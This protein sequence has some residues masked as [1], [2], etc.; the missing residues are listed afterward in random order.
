MVHK[1]NTLKLTNASE[2]D[3]TLII[4]PTQESNKYSSEISKPQ[5]KKDLKDVEDLYARKGNFSRM[6][7]SQLVTDFVSSRNSLPTKAMNR[8]LRKSYE[9]LDAEHS[10]VKSLPKLGAM[11]KRNSTLSKAKTLQKEGDHLSA[12]DLNKTMLSK[13]PGLNMSQRNSFLYQNLNRTLAQ[14]KPSQCGK[15][16]IFRTSQDFSLEESHKMS[17][18][19]LKNMKVLRHVPAKVDKAI[20]D[21]MKEIH[22]LKQKCLERQMAETKRDEN[23]IKSAFIKD[24]PFRLD[25]DLDRDISPSDRQSEN[26]T[27]YWKSQLDLNKKELAKETKS[28][29][30]VSVERQEKTQ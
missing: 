30:K 29:F 3:V 14:L 22:K 8:A 4:K 2:K 15:T 18:M 5:V 11:S 1:I 17:K 6:N 13:H 16:G 26:P 9:P 19:E 28:R 23:L 12:S 27:T 20:V 24:K 10:L 7:Y 21:K 25:L